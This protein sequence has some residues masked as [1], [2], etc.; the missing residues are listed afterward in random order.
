[1][2][3]AWSNPSWGV[4]DSSI[5]DFGG[6]WSKTDVP[7]WNLGSSYGGETYTKKP[8]IRDYAETFLKG[9]KG[10]SSSTSYQA[11]AAA[12]GEEKKEQL[13]A[14]QLFDNFAIYTPPSAYGPGGVGGGATGR[15]TG[16]RIAGGLSGAASGALTGCAF[17]PIGCAV[18]GLGGAIGGAFG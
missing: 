2:A 16:Q 5:P 18:G 10:S 7:G 12:A 17:G 14:Q 6:G 8:G 3:D 13:G 11:K 4:A 9:F 1:M 15:T